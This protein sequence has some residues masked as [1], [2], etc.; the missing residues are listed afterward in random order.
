MAHLTS[1]SHPSYNEWRPYWD[2]MRAAYQGSEVIKSAGVRY[3]PMPGG[4]RYAPNPKA[5]YD[6]YVERAVY[7]EI[8]APTIRGMTGI[9]HSKPSTY[10]LP[11]SLAYLLESASRDGLTLEALHRRVTREVLQVGRYGLLVDM[12]TQGEPLAYVAGYRAEAVLNWDTTEDGRLGMVLLDEAGDERDP[13][14]YEWTRV[15]AWRLLELD[16]SGFYVVRRFRKEGDVVVELE[17]LE[18]RM[19]GGKRLD[20]IPFVF[21]DTNDLAPEPDEIPLLPLANT[22]VN[23]YRL[24][25]DYR[26]ALYLTAMPTPV[27]IGD[28]DPEADFPIMVI[29]AAMPWLVPQ[30]GDAKFLEF[31]GAS[32][33]A[34]R[35]AI[36]DEMERATQLGARLLADQTGRQESGEARR[37]RYASESATLTSIAQNI[38]AGIERA[39]RFAARWSGV[40]PDEVSV[41]P[42]TEFSDATLTS[43]DIDALVR[44]WMAGAFSRYTLFSNLQRGGVVAEGRT[45]EEEM[46]AIESEG[47]SL[48]LVGRE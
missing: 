9:M 24:E 25:A 17:P 14:T 1:T 5:A 7:P 47:E 21:I 36:L 18:P 28:F 20:F 2:M 19:S 12:P 48:G 3:L 15:D 45:F 38:G 29:G 46:E 34:Q 6:E 40:D 33:A 22:A 13:E 39:L 11:D 23:I 41:Q 27:I 26:R 44:G 32:I 35:L 16:E 10:E 31:S 37:L 42:N 43:Q 4:F 30:G 8:L